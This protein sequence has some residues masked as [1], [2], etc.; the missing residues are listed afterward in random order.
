MPR[1]FDTRIYLTFGQPLKR[2]PLTLGSCSVDFVP[3]HI[4]GIGPR[5]FV[6]ISDSPINLTADDARRLAEQLKIAA[7]QAEALQ[8]KA[9][10]R[11]TA[12]CR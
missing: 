4:E 1:D 3:H 9:A 2:E 12:S 11:K 6:I 8:K 5:V 7:C 10:R